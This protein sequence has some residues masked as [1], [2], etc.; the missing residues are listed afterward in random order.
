M[1]FVAY[2]V[3][4]FANGLTFGALSACGARQGP[5]SLASI[6]MNASEERDLMS[7]LIPI[8]VDG[9]A[10]LYVGTMVLDLLGVKKTYKA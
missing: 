8:T 7:R 10:G 2:A 4:G 1:E 6:L 3:A 5:G 9:S